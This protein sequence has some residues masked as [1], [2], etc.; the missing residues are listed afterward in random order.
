MFFWDTRDWSQEQEL[1][2]FISEIHPLLCTPLKIVLLGMGY[3]LLGNDYN[4]RA[5]KKSSPQAADFFTYPHL[6]SSHFPV[7]YTYFVINLK[8]RFLCGGETIHCI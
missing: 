3:E 7:K 5:I 6:P 8:H 4:G 2:P 1:E